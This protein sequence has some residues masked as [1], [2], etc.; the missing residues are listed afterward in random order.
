MSDVQPP[1]RQGSWMASVATE[2]EWQAVLM[3]LVTT[4]GYA[5]FHVFPLMTSRGWR[6]PTTARGIP[7]LCCFRG[8]YTIGIEV[9]SD[10]G[11]ADPDQILWLTRW[12]VLAGGRAW[13][14][15][16]SDDLDTIV[17]WLRDPKDAPRVH[18]F[19]P[20]T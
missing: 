2:R 9:K 4:L 17:A 13:L 3:D 6:T 10:T 1:S 12:S 18:G 14:L 7:D 11:K 20:G 16:P 8:P 19:T 5:H 15:R